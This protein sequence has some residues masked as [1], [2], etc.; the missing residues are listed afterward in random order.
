MA[1]WN[2]QGL[3]QNLEAQYKLPSGLLNGVVRTESGFNPNAVSQVGAQGLMQ[4]MPPT[5]RELGVTNAF[6]PQQNLNGGAKYLSQLLSRYKGD[7][8]LALTAYN[9]G[10][11]NVDAYQKTGKGAK[12]QPIP[13]EARQYAAKV[14]GGMGGSG[15]SGGGGTLTND[16]VVNHLAQ[17]AI[18]SKADQP[19][20]NDDVV[21]QLVALARNAKPQLGA[22]EQSKTVPVELQYSQNDTPEVR[23][24]KRNGRQQYYADL[25]QQA[26]VESAKEAGKTKAWESALLGATDLGAGVV[27]GLDYLKDG[28]ITGI[29]NY[30]GSKFDNQSYERFTKQRSDI[31]EFHNLQRSENDQG[32]DGYRLGG[33]VASTLPMAALARGYQGAKVISQVGARVAAQNAAVGAGIGASSF[34]SDS[35]G[36]AKNTG[37]GAIGGAIGGAVAQKLG[38]AIVAIKNAIS[39]T[40]KQQANA[41]LSTHVN[42]EINIILQQAGIDA[43]SLS[44]AIKQSLQTDVQKALLSGKAADPQSVI[45]KITLE[46]LGLKG[47]QAQISGRPQDWQKSAE[48]AKIQGAGDP[49]RAKFTQDNENLTSLL[50]QAEAK[51]GGKAIDE[52]G[53]M[54]SATKAI[55]DQSSLNKEYIKMAYGSARTAQGNTMPIDA[56]A[57]ADEARQALTSQY[58]NYALPKSVQAL[59]ATAEKKGLTLGD[60][61][62][63]I[64]A[65]NREYA[66]KLNPNG[67]ESAESFAIGLVRSALDKQQNTAV[68]AALASGQPNQAAAYW[69]AGRQAAQAN[70]KRTE[71]NPLVKAVIDGKEPDKLFTQ[72]ILNGNVN[73]IK[74]AFDE[75]GSTS[76]QAIADIKQQ[77]IQNI[78]KRAVNQNGQFSPAGMKRALDAIGDRKLLAMFSKEEVTNLRDIEKAAQYL[79]TQPPHSY[80]NNSN[81]ASALTN[82]FLSFIGKPGVRV[83]LAPVKDVADSLKVKTALNSSVAGMS[84]SQVVQPTLSGAQKQYI[85]LMAKRGVVVT[86]EMLNTK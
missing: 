21:N 44:S 84:P 71:N 5:A 34:A 45:R 64:K 15:G 18:N 12:G 3:L 75:L 1:K 11:G 80:V 27:Q 32:F 22:V 2:D 42:N 68:E 30:A 53:A 39:P 23:A 37:V 61:E 56:K 66:A 38:Q 85:E 29:N 49:L 77:V 83:L 7:Q 54:Q 28:V 69:Q 10:M 51:T 72:Y 48:L 33:A 41:I 82:H 57:F 14:L 86:P 55:S 9:W 20:Q 73:N 58:A 74:S 36:R 70:F 8:N 47:A 40:A 81:T 50:G 26:R 65:L 17:L 6:D 63:L 60:S 25:Q 43:A 62:E 46:K 67:T 78:S 4:L 59:M 35:S 13:A 24:A 52:Y 16:D 76:P 31:D 79:I 19:Q